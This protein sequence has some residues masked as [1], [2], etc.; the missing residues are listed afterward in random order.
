M[1]KLKRDTGVSHHIFENIIRNEFIG[2]GA[3]VDLVWIQALHSSR[4]GSSRR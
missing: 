3:L 4:T 2:T 1:G